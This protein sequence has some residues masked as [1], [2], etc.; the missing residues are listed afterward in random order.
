M[1]VPTTIREAFNH[2]LLL[3][4]SPSFGEWLEPQAYFKHVLLKHE[5]E[6]LL[7][8]SACEMDRVF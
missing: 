7:K 1:K 2:R 6:Q 3:E 5:T 4:N 8:I